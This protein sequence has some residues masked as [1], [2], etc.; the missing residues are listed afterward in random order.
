[1]RCEKLLTFYWMNFYDLD[2]A[3][4]TFHDGFMKKTIYKILTRKIFANLQHENYYTGKRGSE[5]IWWGC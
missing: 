1:M 5:R 2:F 4:Y 3:C